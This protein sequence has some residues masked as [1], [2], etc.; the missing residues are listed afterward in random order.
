MV[1]LREE[2][3]RGPE[4]LRGER[5]ATL[6]VAALTSL[7]GLA[8]LL[9]SRVVFLRSDGRRGER[10]PDCQMKHRKRSHRRQVTSRRSRAQ[11]F[12]VT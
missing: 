5:V 10:H 12:R 8:R 1:R 6:G 9:S 4:A 2:I 11:C 3:E 7:E